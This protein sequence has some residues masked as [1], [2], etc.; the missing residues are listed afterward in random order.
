MSSNHS[1]LGG[2]RRF[3][4]VATTSRSHVLTSEASFSAR[5]LSSTSGAGLCRTSC[6]C[7]SSLPWRSIC[8]ALRSSARS[9]GSCSEGGRSAGFARSTS[10]RTAAASC[11]RLFSKVPAMNRVTVLANAMGCGGCLR[12]ES[13]MMPVRGWFNGHMQCR[14]GT[15]T[16]S[17]VPAA[18]AYRTFIFGFG[19]ASNAARPEYQNKRF[20]PSVL[21]GGAHRVRSCV[22]RSRFV[23]A[24]QSAGAGTAGLCAAAHLSRRRLQVGLPQPCKG[25]TYGSGGCFCDLKN[26]ETDRGERRPHQGHPLCAGRCA[27]LP[28]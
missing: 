21:Y 13:R 10:L 20:A 19:L 9:G 5:R 11:C 8:S 14:P 17:L 4:A 16:T 22:W 23:T 12:E 26:E 3:S 2:I 1:P 7:A 25:I 18:A 6:A 28:H 15:G 24:R 27:P